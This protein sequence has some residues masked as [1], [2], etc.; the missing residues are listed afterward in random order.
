MYHVPDGVQLPV[1]HGRAVAELHRVAAPGGGVPV[2]ASVSAAAQGPVVAAEP[3]ALRQSRQV[4]G[5]GGRE[6]LETSRAGGVRVGSNIGNKPRWRR[7][8]RIEHS[9][10]SCAGSL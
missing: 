6:A 4:P 3:S 7:P 10:T 9:E 8:R 5:G 2:P 1:L